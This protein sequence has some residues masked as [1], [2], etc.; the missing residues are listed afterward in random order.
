MHH[1]NQIRP[2][3]SHPPTRSLALFLI[4]VGLLLLGISLSWVLPPILTTSPLGSERGIAAAQRNDPAPALTLTDLD[5]KAVS[6]ADYSGYVLLVNNWATWCPPCREEM[7][8]LQAYYEDH[9][10]KGFVLIGIEAGDSA[11]E[12]RAFVQQYG[13]TFPIW[14]DAQNQA[15][16]AF[17]NYALPN[18]YLIDRQGKVIM[19]WTGAL[20]RDVMERYITPVLED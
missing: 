2:R 16:R 12:V 8:I 11:A 4:G 3:G 20:S 18:S 15:L 5:G 7:P 6:L 1:S 17:S 19:G 13:L 9:R 10:D 14:L